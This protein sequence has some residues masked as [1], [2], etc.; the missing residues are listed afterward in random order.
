MPHPKSKTLSVDEVYAL[1][2]YILNINEMKI[3][4]VEVDDEYVLDR[5]KFLE[6]IM[7]NVNGF[8]PN[9]DGPNALNNVRAYYANP[10]NFGAIKVNPSDRC[11]TDCQDKSAKI[12][13]IK[14]GGI[15]DFLP[16]MSDK[17]DLP[18]EKV[19]LDVKAV[20]TDNCAMCHGNGVGPAF[21]NPSEWTPYTSKGMDKVYANAIHGTDG[22][23]P[24]KGG[25]TLSDA[26]FKSVVDYLISGK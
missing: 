9:I 7:P 12:V 14:N 6:V 18:K 17:R 5:K 21:A 10:K 2:A 22:G 3:N 11:M 25:S 13:R 23:M 20:Y 16:P 26:D 4:G 15:K 19:V 8:E 1:V 24:P